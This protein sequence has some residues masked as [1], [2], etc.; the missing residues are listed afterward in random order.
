MNK[1][2]PKTASKAT[3]YRRIESFKQLYETKT[4]TIVAMKLYFNLTKDW[5]R[6]LNIRDDKFNRV[7]ALE[8]LRAW[9]EEQVLDRAFDN[10]KQAYTKYW[11]RAFGN[12]YIDK[13]EVQ[14]PNIIVQLAQ[15]RKIDND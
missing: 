3:F 6:D 8:N 11:D 4:P 12:D 10:D 13:E 15:E 7:W 9:I 14:M 1:F 5:R 2:S